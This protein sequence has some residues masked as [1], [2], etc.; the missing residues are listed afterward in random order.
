MDL[1]L[2]D[3]HALMRRLDTL[4]SD[5]YKTRPLWLIGALLL[6]SSAMAVDAEGGAQLP[7]GAQKVAERRYRAKLDF[8]ETL[9]YFKARYPPSSYPRKAI[10]NQPGIKAV[11]IVNP[12]K[13]GFEGLNVYSANDEVRIFV[14]PS[15]V[16]VKL[17]KKSKGK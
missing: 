4:A 16:E 2:S 13:K 11:H 14:V 7:D 3:D 12:S 10:V 6:A 9:K 5:L 15:A 17:K 1:S 8:E